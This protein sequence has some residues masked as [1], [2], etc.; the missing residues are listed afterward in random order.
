MDVFRVHSW[1][2]VLGAGAEIEELRWLGSAPDRA[3]RLGSVL[4]REILPRL[5]RDGLIG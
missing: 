3:L 5:T 2:G 1:S 4:A